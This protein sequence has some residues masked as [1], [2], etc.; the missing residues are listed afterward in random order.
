[1]LSLH[2]NAAA[3]STLNSIG[4]NQKEL[5]GSQTKLGT[6]YRVNSSMDDAAGLQ[7]AT[8][9]DAQSRGMTVASRNTQNATSLLQ[10]ADGAL[11]EL[12]NVLL[13]MKDLATQAADD[14]SSATDRAAMQAEFDALGLE[15][16]NILNNT[17][18]GGSKLLMGGKLGAAMTFQIGASSAE[19]MAFDVS[20]DVTAL[21]TQLGTV[22]SNYAAVSGG[23]GNEITTQAGANAMINTIGTALD[24]VGTVRGG[25]GAAGNRL[26]HVYNNLQ[27]ISGNT[28]NARGRIMDVDYASESANMTAHQML[29]QAGTSMLK[30]TN[31]LAGLTMSLLQ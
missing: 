16:Y 31:S 6:G 28:Q 27:N 19:K 5:A 13:R 23:A 24:D 11:N 30:Q 12:S 14:S 29:L 4:M 3:L 7:I 21:D 15:T 1:M 26:D 9:L 8:R 20:A 25:I 18:Y 10:T 2:T 17:Q 22:S